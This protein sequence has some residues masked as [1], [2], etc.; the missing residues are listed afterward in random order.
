M[1]HIEFGQ[2]LYQLSPK[3]MKHIE[4]GQSLY[5]LSPKLRKHIEFFF[6]AIYITMVQLYP[7]L[8]DINVLCNESGL[9]SLDFGF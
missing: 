4:F 5:Q 2:S 7:L 6:H 8:N 3:L 9:M 1:K